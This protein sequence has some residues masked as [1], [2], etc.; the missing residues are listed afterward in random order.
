MGLRTSEPLTNYPFMFCISQDDSLRR[1]D[2]GIVVNIS[3]VNFITNIHNSVHRIL[4]LIAL[5]QYLNSIP[6]PT[7][8]DYSR[9]PFR[10]LFV[11]NGNSS[12]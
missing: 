6:Y 10:F 1:Q 8:R 9:G 3:V 12:Q 2:M 5:R 7:K 11:S 4:T